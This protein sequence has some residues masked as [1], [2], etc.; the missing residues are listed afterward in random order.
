MKEQL[1]KLNE[2]ITE[3]NKDRKTRGKPLVRLISLREFGVFLGLLLVA[4]LEGKKGK[5]LWKGDK[6]QGEGY[7]SQVDMSMHMK[8]YRHAEI[9]KYFAY[10]FADRSKKDDDPWWQILDG[11]EGF[12]SNRKRVVVL[13]M[14]LVIDESMSAHRMRTTPKGRLFLDHMFIS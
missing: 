6:R 2:Q 3:D 10:L 11:I 4:R 13:G 12:N 14:E 8:A 7:R 1:T 5:N 9:K